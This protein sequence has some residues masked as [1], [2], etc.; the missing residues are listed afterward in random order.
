MSIQSR[1]FCLFALLAT[2]AACQGPVVTER[3]II[4]TATPD[5]GATATFEAARAATEAVPTATPTLTPT[6]DP[7]PTP[8][9]GAI[10]VAQQRFERGWMFW[11]Q[12]NQQIWL[13]SVNDRDEHLWSVYDDNFV[14]GD[15]ESDPE[16]PVPEGMQQPVRGFGKLWRENLEVRT[17]I[18]YALEDELG[19]TTRYEYHHGG[20][21]GANNQYIS[22]PGYHLVESL[23]GDTFRFNEGDSTWQIAE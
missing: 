10:Y 12:P 13:L 1:L 23:Y 3:V 7:F 6:P 18:G 17:A 9:I 15:I 4:V 11:L 2:L 16:I 8:V 5:G 14:D 19:H 21:L 22:G 20:A